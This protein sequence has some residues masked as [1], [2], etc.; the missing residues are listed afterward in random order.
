MAKIRHLAPHIISQ[1]AAGEV[2]DRP[3]SIIKELVENALDAKAA[4]ID[5]TLV[6]GGLTKIV[7][8]DDGLGMS[9][10]DLELAALRHTTSKVIDEADLHKI[11]S[12][13]FRGEALSSIA[14]VSKLTIRSREQDSEKGHSIEI[15]HG[16]VGAVSA[17]G[18]PTG[19]EIIIEEL[20]AHT[21]VRKKFQKDSSQEIK[22]CLEYCMRFGLAYPHVGLKLTHNTETLLVLPSNQSLDARIKQ[23]IRDGVHH[24]LLPLQYET[25]YGKINGFIGHPQ[26]A[27]NRP[28]QFLFVNNRPLTAR[29]IGQIITEKYGSLIE[30]RTAPHFV[31]FLELPFETVDVNIHPRKEEVAFSNTTEIEKLVREAI[32]ETLDAHTMTYDLDPQSLS[33]DPRE[34]RG[35]DY[36]SADLVKNVS[37]AWNLKSSTDAGILQI[38]NLYLVAPTHQGLLLI[39]QHAAH[40]RILYEQFKKELKLVPELKQIVTLPTPVL[41]HLSPSDSAL[42]ITHLPKLAELGFDLEPFGMHTFKLTEVPDFFKERDFEELIL[43]VLHDL[44]NGNADKLDRETDRMLAYL[45]CRSAIKAGDPLD[46]A[47]RVRL[48]E[49]L[50]ETPGSYTCPHG[51]PTHI[52]LSLK[53]LATLFKR[54]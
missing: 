30:P 39:D 52:E 43:N 8:K 40:E 13:G 21:P 31:L 48:V 35:M 42:L 4:N 1:I 49:K 7:C 45:A 11:S 2:A 33:I 3:A 26:T 23:I 14:A 18:I 54:H 10:E 22:S 24:R 16:K 6:D 41:L 9:A 44:S 37:A 29:P 51:R 32:G 27:N 28:S 36:Y 17:V 46:P 34:R 50:L 19:T 25:Q 53:D 12:F 5:I 15:N 47:E 20:F 38:D